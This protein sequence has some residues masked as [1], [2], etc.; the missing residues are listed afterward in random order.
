MSYNLG[1]EFKGSLYH[2]GKMSVELLGENAPS[3]VALPTV[4]C[5]NE[6][7]FFLVEWSREGTEEASHQKNAE[8]SL[9][10]CGLEIRQKISC[11]IVCFV[12]LLDS[13]PLQGSWRL[14]I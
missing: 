5:R 7:F 3:G 12:W 9:K 2:Q 4:L 10:S 13:P 8:Q 1:K 6:P 14:F 11:S